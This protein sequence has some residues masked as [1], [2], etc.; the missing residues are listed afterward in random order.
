MFLLDRQCTVGALWRGLDGCFDQLLLVS[1]HSVSRCCQMISVHMERQ[2]D[3]VVQGETLTHAT[4][5]A[6][7]CVCFCMCCSLSRIWTR[8]D[9]MVHG[10]WCD[11]IVILFYCRGSKDDFNGVTVG[12]ETA[13]SAL[14]ICSIESDAAQWPPNAKCR[15]VVC[16]YEQPLRTLSG[17]PKQCPG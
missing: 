16:E 9:E 7:S 17:K 11:V 5:V 12:L 13:E 10:T 3:C 8:G 14:R 6:G 1:Q 4:K 15:K 2:I